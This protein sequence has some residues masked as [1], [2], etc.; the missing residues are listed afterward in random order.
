MDT[1][2]DPQVRCDC[3][4]LVARLT[5]LGVEIKCKRCKRITIIPVKNKNPK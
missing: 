5:S 4:Q 1:T 3:G 2:E